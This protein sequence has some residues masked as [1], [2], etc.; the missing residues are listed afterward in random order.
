MEA[1][2][3]TLKQELL[4]AMVCTSL[5]I[6]KQ[7]CAPNAMVATIWSHLA[8]KA[9]E[10]MLG[11][12]NRQQPWAHR[13][14]QRDREPHIGAPR[15]RAAPSGSAPRQRHGAGRPFPRERHARGA[16]PN[17]AP[18]TLPENGSPKNGRLRSFA[19]GIPYPAVGPPVS[20]LMKFTEFTL[21][22]D[23]HFTPIKYSTQND[24]DPA[25]RRRL[26][27]KVGGEPLL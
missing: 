20:N 26:T 15:C 19:P 16:A 5:T 7:I 24:A 22:K 2:F 11:M 3:G 9:L 14:G 27:R 13:Q 17:V 10:F 8:P 23:K 18:R 12:T 25:K 1:E 4:E 21:L 6:L